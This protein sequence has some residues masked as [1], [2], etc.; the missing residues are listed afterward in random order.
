M[1]DIL[2]VSLLFYN[3]DII[4]KHIDFLLTV[5]DR[6]DII[7]I[8]NRSEISNT[9]KKICID[10]IKLRKVLRYYLFDENVY[11]K[12]L[13][14][15]IYNNENEISRYKYVIV[16]DGDLSCSDPNWLQEELDILNKYNNTFCCVTDL[17][18]DNLPVKSHP[19]SVGWVPS[20]RNIGEDYIEGLSGIHLAMFRT[21]EFI[22]LIN[23]LKSNGFIFVDIRLHEYADRHIHKKWMKTK[24]AKAYHY[25]WDTYQDLQSYYS[26]KKI[27]ILNNMH[28]VDKKCSYTLFYLDDFDMLIEKIGEI[29]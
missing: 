2:I 27:H 26:I 18:M 7:F 24:I 10:L 22:D 29:K 4:R 21:N 14:E 5:S 19:A 23:Y 17:V 1:K 13:E 16:T 6:A 3:E 8:E 11:N 25:T 15:Y 28:E 20:P 12:A 9:I